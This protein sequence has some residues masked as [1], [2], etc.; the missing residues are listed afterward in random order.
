MQPEAQGF[1][2]CQLKKAI[3]SAMQQID[4]PEGAEANVEVTLEH[5]PVG[6]EGVD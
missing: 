6:C 1:T 3:N 5:A 2:D 4:I